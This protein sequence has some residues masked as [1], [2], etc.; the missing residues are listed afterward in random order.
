MEKRTTFF[1]AEDIP[2]FLGR[3]YAACGDYRGSVEAFS[4]A[5]SQTKKP[6]DSLLMSIAR[7]YMELEEYTIAVSYLQLCIDTSQDSNLIQIAR[8]L[9]AEVFLL[10]GDLDK[11]ENQYISILNDGDNAEVHYQLGELYSLKGDAVRARSQW[12]LAYRQDP[13]HA[14]ARARLNL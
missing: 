8:I 3:A 1:D 13:A 14:Q 5:L 9:L 12:R 10:S 4:K 6:S 2:L 11:A 7:S